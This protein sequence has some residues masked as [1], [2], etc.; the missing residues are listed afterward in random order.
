MLMLTDVPGIRVGHWT[1]AEAGTG[2]TAIILPPGTCGGVDVR[3]GGP[4][5]RETDLLRPEATVP[6][7]S[8]I[9]LS[10]GSAFGLDSATGVMQWCEEQGLG[11][12]TGI[13]VVPIVPAACL[14]DL[15]ITGNA[16][17][18]G[19]SEGRL[20]AEAATDGP[21]AVG[22][23]GAGTG[24]T[25]GK[26]HGRDHWCKGG[27][28]T[29]SVRLPSG[30][31]VAALVAVNA[32]GDVLGEDGAVIA[33]TWEEGRGFVDSRLALLDGAARHARVQDMSNT[34]LCV[35]ATDARLDKPGCTHLARQAHA[36]LARAIAPYGTALDG[37][38]AF[39]VS[40]GQIEANPVVVGNAAAEVATRAVRD[41]VRQA[42]SVRGVPTAA[43]LTGA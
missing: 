7:V 41:A 20:A 18:P 3:G 33:G 25:V 22:S 16:R 10:G 37:D 15:G 31:T 34:T 12:D 13:A 42:T 28:G 5:S 6:I 32:F 21:H 43:D 30:A 1:D 2:C 23:V 35:I 24:A 11:V 36:G 8:A 9:V 29:A 4:A 17:R 26:C 38:I 14:F 39:A 27:I 19:A 40:T